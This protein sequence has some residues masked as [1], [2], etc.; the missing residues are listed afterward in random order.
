MKTK[1]TNKKKIREKREK[2]KLK[3]AIVIII[4]KTAVDKLKYNPSKKKN[5]FSDRVSVP[6]WR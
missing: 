1:Q 3:L 4:P 2:K 6:V 5:K